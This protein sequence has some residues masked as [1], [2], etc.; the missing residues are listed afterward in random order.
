MIDMYLVAAI[1]K[2]NDVSINLYVENDSK[3]IFQLALGHFVQLIIRLR[4]A[5]FTLS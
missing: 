3:H 5:S 4:V 1:R 2:F